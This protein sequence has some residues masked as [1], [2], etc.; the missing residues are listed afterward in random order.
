MNV[1][2]NSNQDLAARID[3]PSFLMKIRGAMLLSRKSFS[4]SYKS[5]KLWQGYFIFLISVGLLSF[6]LSSSTYPIFMK[7]FPHY[8]FSFN[9]FASITWISFSPEMMIFSFLIFGGFWLLISSSISYFK[10]LDIKRTASALGFSFSPLLILI[11]YILNK[12]L[13]QSFKFELGSL[14][15]GIGLGWSGLS[16][17]IGVTNFIGIEFGGLINFSLKSIIF[18]R[19]R[20]Y[21]AIIGIAVAIGL[22]VTPIPIISGYYMQLNNLAQQNQY[23]QYLILLEKGK[24]NYYSSKINITNLSSVDQPNVL[25]ISPETYLNVNISSEKTLQQIPMRGINFTIF[26]DFRNL[27]PFQILPGKSFS[28]NQVL[29]GNCLATLLNISYKMLPINFSLSYKSRVYNITIIGLVITN[30]QYDYELLAPIN[31]TYNLEPTLVGKISLIEIKLTNPSLGDST[32][33][34]LQAE[35]PDLDI[36]RENNLKNFVSEIISRTIQ[37]IWLLSFVIYIVMAFGMFHIMQTII[38]ESELEIAILKSI[39]AN[40]FQIIRIYLYQS[41][42]LCLLGSGLGVLCGMLL[43][44]FASILVS[45]ITTIIVRPT[46]DIFSIGCAIILGVSSGVVG[47]LYPAYSG[48]KTVVGVKIR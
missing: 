45:S 16:A 48:S 18:R 19:K 7:F 37:S 36:M 27:H 3:E 1:E 32:I 44:Y 13:L 47:G 9:L 15:L 21:A 30:I 43:S 4:V 14:L 31:L 29:M 11:F 22:I 20:T 35:N 33:Q 34:V 26:Q 2:N 12:F 46:F 38:K 17:L 42:L 39:G 24:T 25:M 10:K 6:V 23:S 41:I 8:E 5:S 28:E 40:N